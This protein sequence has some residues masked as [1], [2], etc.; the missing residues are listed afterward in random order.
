VR[1]SSRWY[2]AGLVC[3]LAGVAAH[4]TGNRYEKRER[5]ETWREATKKE[6]PDGTATVGE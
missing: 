5:D 1:V 2:I 3:S 6:T 4:I